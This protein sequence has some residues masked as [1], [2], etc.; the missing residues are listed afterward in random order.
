L[1]QDTSLVDLEFALTK[2][3]NFASI[4]S[5]YGKVLAIDKE[6]EIWSFY[7]KRFWFIPDDGQDLDEEP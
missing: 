2:E 1:K 5:A 6:G 3:Q 4:Y 7:D